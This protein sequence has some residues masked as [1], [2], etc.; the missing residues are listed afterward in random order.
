MEGW[1]EVAVDLL[2]ILAALPCIFLLVTIDRFDFHL[3]AQTAIERI[4]VSTAAA[5]SLFL[6]AAVFVQATRCR[7]RQIEGKPQ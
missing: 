7:K 2:Q 4:G 3:P 6:F 1:I 5:A